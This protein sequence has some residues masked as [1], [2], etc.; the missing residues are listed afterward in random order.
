LAGQYKNQRTYHYNT[1]RAFNNNVFRYTIINQRYG[2]TYYTAGS[3]D[4]N[5]DKYIRAIL[6]ME[7]ISRSVVD[8][9]YQQ[10]INRE[11]ML[12]FPQRAVW[13]SDFFNKTANNISKGTLDS[14]AVIG[15]L[16]GWKYDIGAKAAE[17]G[18][19]GFATFRQMLKYKQEAIK[20]GQE[21]YYSITDDAYVLNIMAGITSKF[22]EGKVKYNL[23]IKAY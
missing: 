21:G 14:T 7:A 9:A 20:Q 12:F 5:I 1:M 17:A 8:I 16:V 3:V 11:V 22:L 6:T 23:G 18:L 13:M 15:G 4:D 2:K 19:S 10:G